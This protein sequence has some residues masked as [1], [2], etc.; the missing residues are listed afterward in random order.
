M[1]TRSLLVRYLTSHLLVMTVFLITVGTALLL[2]VNRGLELWKQTEGQS[3][4]DFVREE[5]SQIYYVAEF[6]EGETV[7]E[8][9]A[10]FLDPSVFLY[11]FN[12]RKE[13]IFW[14]RNGESWYLEDSRTE[15]IIADQAGESVSAVLSDSQ[16]FP[17]ANPESPHNKPVF[18]QELEEEGVLEPV[19]VGDDAVAYFSA[20]SNGFTINRQNKQLVDT[21]VYAVLFGL[22]AAVIAGLSFSLS[23]VR[24]TGA[25]AAR[26][27][28]DIHALAHGDRGRTLPDSPI[29][30]LQSIVESVN[31]FT[32]RLQEE[33]GIR[34]QWVL[35]I[36]HDLK[37]P[38]TGIR[39]QLEGLIDGVLQASMDRFQRILNEV[40]RVESLSA[41]FLLLTRIESPDMELSPAP[42]SSEEL[43]EMVNDRFS[44]RLKS[45]NRELVIVSRPG[46]LHVDRH[47]FQR[48]VSN[49]VENAV[50][51]G[52][53]TVAITI[54]AMSVVVENSGHIDEEVLPRIFDRL[55][56][57]SMDRSGTGMGLGLTIARAVVEKHNGTIAVRNMQDLVQVEIVLSKKELS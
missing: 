50:T 3:I 33:E 40:S 13:L 10:P 7:E 4:Q 2:G 45:Q 44:E 29:R 28:G 55:Y 51:H 14:Y 52:S 25:H 11:V 43:A 12:G 15:Q 16:L 22:V 5:L 26:I 48:A 18:Y 54:S 9:L 17:W 41:G 37:T 56:R 36:A 34:R 1:K 47:L 32:V 31:I 27:A 8:Y 24:R 53:G 57:G 35:D 20:G 39:A 38:L 46:T 21:M 6:S 23:Q 42:L 19:Y 49:I 30:E